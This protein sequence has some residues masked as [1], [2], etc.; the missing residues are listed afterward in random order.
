MW[1]FLG[2]AWVAAMLLAWALTKEQQRTAE[3]SILKPINIPDSEWQSA[4]AR[5]GEKWL[6]AESSLSAERE[7]HAKTKVEL[8]RVDAKRMRHGLDL[9]DA[10]TRADRA[11]AI[12]RGLR[13]WVE[14]R[15]KAGRMAV[16]FDR[17][18]TQLEALEAT[19][20]DDRR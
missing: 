15:V 4:C 6:I 18:L 11:E 13:A 20:A 10:L 17:L 7:A 5:A 9:S 12:L 2:I 3:A 1:I 19:H 16:D 14:S 8:E